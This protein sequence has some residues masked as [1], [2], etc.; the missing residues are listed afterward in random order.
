MMMIMANTFVI[1]V[2]STVLADHL[3]SSS[4]DD[5]MPRTR[6][7]ALIIYCCWILSTLL[8]WKSLAV[9]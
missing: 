2:L 6:A 5:M 9:Q 8:V 1:L 3:L 7:V 4:E